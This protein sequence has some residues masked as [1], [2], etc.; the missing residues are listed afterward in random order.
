MLAMEPHAFHGCFDSSIP[1]ILEFVGK[2]LFG[3]LTEEKK[4]S[5]IVKK[6]PEAMKVVGYSMLE[7]LASRMSKSLVCDVISGLLNTAVSAKSIFDALQKLRKA[8]KS[9]QTGL[10]RNKDLE[11]PTDYLQLSYGI[12]SGQLLSAELVKAHSATLREFAFSLLLAGTSDA[13]VT[14]AQIRPFWPFLRD[15]LEN[16]DVNVVVACLK[17]LSI[18]TQNKD[19]CDVLVRI[20][21]IPYR[22]EGCLWF[23]LFF[24]VLSQN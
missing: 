10:A 22:A 19:V 11:R 9:I 4:V 3:S 13:A 6:T 1:K 17:F 12:L 15:A 21:T 7:S 5:A 24:K 16:K 18:V 14:G 23:F 8:I 2:E 20:D